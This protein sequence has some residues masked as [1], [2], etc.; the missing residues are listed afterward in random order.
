MQNS[1]ENNINNLKQAAVTSYY[2]TVVFDLPRE[3]ESQSTLYPNPDSFNRI[4][5]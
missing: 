2:V 3:S 5:P 4:C 1:T